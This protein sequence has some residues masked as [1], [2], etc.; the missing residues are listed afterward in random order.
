MSAARGFTLIEMLISVAL[1]VMV[2]AMTWTAFSRAKAATTRASARVGLHQGAAILQDAIERDAANLAP[3]LGLFITSTPA[4]AATTRSERLDLTFMRSAA[5]L[6]KQNQ[7]H[8]WDRHLADHHWVR[9]HFERSLELKDG[10]WRV[11]SSRLKRSASTPIRF[12][13]TTATLP[14]YGGY[15]W[16]NIPRP[17]R[18]AS[19]GSASLDANRYGVPAG[20]IDP[21]TLIG[22]IGDKQDLDANEQLVSDRVTDFALGWVRADGTAVQVLSDHA[23]PEICIDGLYMDVVGPDEGRYLDARQEPVLPDPY[24]NPTVPYNYRPVLAA[25]PRLLR[26]LFRMLDRATGVEQSFAFSVVL[27][28]MRPAINEPSR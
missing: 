24:V 23:G 14:G 18:D 3:A 4:A 13:Q 10:A 21:S 22:D 8:D 17:L 26:V 19:Q 11:V 5:P 2:V 28:G 15:Q 25:R 9:W 27:P 16:V 1:G 6:D 12:W 7:Q 20:A